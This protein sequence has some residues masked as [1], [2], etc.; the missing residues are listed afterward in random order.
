[1]NFPTQTDYHRTANEIARKNNLGQETFGG[2]LRAELPFGFIGFSGYMNRFDQ[3]IAQGTQPYQR[4][5][6]TGRDLTALSADLRILLG[7]VILFSEAGYTD[8][9]GYGVL[10]GAEIE[11][12]ENTDAALAT[13]ITIRHFIPF[14]VQ[15]SGNRQVLPG[16]KK[17]SI[18]EFAIV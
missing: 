7:S 6:F 14:S 3:T 13:A 11:I 17:A 12:G 9:G 2:R 10:T 4:Y 5:R 8:N 15:L 18:S 1:M 16:M